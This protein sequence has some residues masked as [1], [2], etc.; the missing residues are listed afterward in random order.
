[1]L[2]LSHSDL[3]PSPVA[4][5][6]SLPPTLLL[7]WGGLG[8]VLRWKELALLS[9]SRKLDSASLQRLCCGLPV[10]V[11]GQ[12]ACNSLQH[13]SV[14]AAFQPVV[15]S[16]LPSRE[17]FFLNFF[18]VNI[19]SESTFVSFCLPR[20][21]FFSQEELLECEQSL[22]FL[23]LVYCMVR[24]TSAVFPSWRAAVVANV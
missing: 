2:L 15:G 24:I 21:Q 16:S 22:C 9:C 19:Q 12:T 3:F 8:V 17:I 11:S 1:M 20:P 4:S 7:W 18:S 6:P 13:S 5:A 23:L 10:L 14:G